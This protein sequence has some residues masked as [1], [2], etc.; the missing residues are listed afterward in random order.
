MCQKYPEVMPPTFLRSSFCFVKSPGWVWH[1]VFGFLN[2]EMYFPVL[3]GRM[4]ILLFEI[5]IK[6]GRVPESALVTDV[7]YSQVRVL[8]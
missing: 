6:M 7:T 5:I 8:Q 1:P 2:A 4:F 3:P